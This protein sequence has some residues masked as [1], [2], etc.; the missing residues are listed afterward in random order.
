MRDVSLEKWGLLRPAARAITTGAP[1]AGA[2]GVAA[3]QTSC[4]VP[5]TPV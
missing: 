3:Y 5:V 2:V 1:L 4:E